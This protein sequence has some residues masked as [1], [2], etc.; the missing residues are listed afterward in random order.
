MTYRI[1]VSKIKEKSSNLQN[2][3]LEAAFQSTHKRKLHFLVFYFSSHKL[4]PLPYLKYAVV[5]RAQ[6][7][8]RQEK[9]KKKKK[10]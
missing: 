6:V 5:H 8:G 2:I 10:H 4:H 9:R 3:I 7:N 1:K